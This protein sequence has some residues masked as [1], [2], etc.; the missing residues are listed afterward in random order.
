MKIST[1]FFTDF[2]FRVREEYLINK[3]NSYGFNNVIP[4]RKEW[5]DKTQ[6]YQEN[7]EIL[8]QPRGCGYWLWKP[9]II[10][11]TMKNLEYNDC[12]FYTDAGD[13]IID[14]V[15][16]IIYDYM[17]NHDYILSNFLENDRFSNKV[18]TKRD[19]FI[20]MN[21]DEAKY[22]NIRMVEAG[23]IV[24]KKTEFII[25]LLNEWINYGRNKYIITDTPNTLGDN[26]PGFFDHR[27]DQSIL[28]NLTAKYDMEF[29][30]ILLP[31]IQYNFFGQNLK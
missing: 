6:F 27:H 10:L 11:E 4:Y 12:V 14:N 16:S 7:R 30:H 8:D 31:H 2:K 5:L 20:L 9:Y 21:C 26:L 17:L 1:I 15:Y 25:N 24:F 23:T 18:Y 22:H 19:C 28:A 3:F 13:E 29:V